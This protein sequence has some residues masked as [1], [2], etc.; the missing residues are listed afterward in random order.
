MALIIISALAGT[1]KDDVSSPVIQAKN[2][3]TLS[4][5]SL[6]EFKRDV[7]KIPTTQ[8][9]QKVQTDGNDTASNMDQK[10]AI[11]QQQPTGFIN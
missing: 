10:H 7:L 11:E 4:K 1:I 5:V 9:T 3:Q 2:F 8:G 6:W